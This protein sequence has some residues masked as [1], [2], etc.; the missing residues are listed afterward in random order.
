M[1][2]EEFSMQIISIYNKTK[3]TRK[4]KINVQ[5]YK[6]L[7]FMDRKKKLKK[8]DKNNRNRNNNNKFIFYYLYS[9]I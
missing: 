6:N 2:K 5:K 8:T 7:L 3:D 4:Q 1:K 9:T